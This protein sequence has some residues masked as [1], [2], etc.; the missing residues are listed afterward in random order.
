MEIKNAW[1]IFGNRIGEVLFKVKVPGIIEIGDTLTLNPIYPRIREMDF[2]MSNDDEMSAR[3]VSDV[4]DVVKS[5]IY[6]IGLE[7]YDKGPIRLDYVAR[8]IN[9]AG[10]KRL[11]ARGFCVRAAE[12]EKGLF[13]CSIPKTFDPVTLEV[14]FKKPN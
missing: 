13:N 7:I 9:E 5:N 10:E 1:F 2:D 6:R 14:Q 4:S 12:G 8:W 3:V 11:A